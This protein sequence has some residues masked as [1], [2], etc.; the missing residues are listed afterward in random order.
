MEGQGMS[1]RRLTGKIQAS[2][3]GRLDLPKVPDGVIDGFKALG[4]DLSSLVSDVLDE[5]GIA[6]AIGASVLRPIYAEAAIVGRAL[7]LRNI[8][9][10]NSP[11]KGA[12]DKI[13]RLAEIEAHN[14]AEPGD[15]LV[16]EGV[17]GVSN[18]GGI[19]AAIGKRQGEIGAI[20]DGGVRDVGECRSIDYPMW[21]RDV[22]PLTGKWRVQ[23]VAINMPVEIAGVQVIPGDI[24]IA[25]ET[26]ICFVPIE[27]AQAVLDRARDIHAAEARRQT[28]I[29]A[30]V[31]VPDLANRAGSFTMPK[32]D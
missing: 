6:K 8:V 30:G 32:Q 10:G 14:L 16:I 1:E 23:T 22:T 5:M 18:I 11:Y 4:S 29:A 26:G 20:V 31:S 15:V 2:G 7:T 9:Q 27:L 24:V 28:D 21:S 13:S 19:S 17:A 12:S 3:I 25:D